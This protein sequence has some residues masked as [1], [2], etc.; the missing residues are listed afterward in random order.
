MP[1]WRV[2]KS[3][4]RML[5]FCFVETRA[6]EVKLLS[7]HFHLWFFW[8]WFLL[9]SAFKSDKCSLWY[10]SSRKTQFTSLVE[11]PKQHSC[12]DAYAPSS[13]W[14]TLLKT[15]TC[16]LV[17]VRWIW[18]ESGTSF[19]PI[20]CTSLSFYVGLSQIRFSLK[21]ILQL[22]ETSNRNITGAE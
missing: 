2:P 19:R 15:P 16:V 10:W 3:C 22:K 4:F 14:R 20:S 13:D 11:R 17:H 6:R 7:E 12:H 21:R 8:N 1:S 9:T 18:T 5:Q